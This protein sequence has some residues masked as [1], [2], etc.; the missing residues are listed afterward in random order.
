MRRLTALLAVAI[1]ATS[2][3]ACSSGDRQAVALNEVAKRGFENPTLMHA[4]NKSDIVAANY[5]KCRF[6]FSVDE[7]G[8][9]TL[10]VRSGSGKDDIVIE[11]PNAALLEAQQ[12]DTFGL[13][14]YTAE[15]DSSQS[16]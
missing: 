11:N 10:T 7:K 3:S 9:I 13:C 8:H 14:G 12:P 15:A 6:E 5:G 2:L 16:E 1:L 4:G